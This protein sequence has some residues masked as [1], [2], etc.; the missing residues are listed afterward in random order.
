MDFFSI[1]FEQEEDGRWIAEIPAIPGVMVY[2]ATRAQAGENAKSLAFLVLS[3]G[4]GLGYGPT[5]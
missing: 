1:D 3:Q 5:G 2:G 4:G